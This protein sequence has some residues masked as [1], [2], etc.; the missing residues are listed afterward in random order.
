MAVDVSAVAPRAINELA[1]EKLFETIL[2]KDFT[3]FETFVLT[4]GFLPWPGRSNGTC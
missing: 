1:P 3:G 2:D 4:F